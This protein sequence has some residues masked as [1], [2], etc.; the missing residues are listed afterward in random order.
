M[1]GMHPLRSL[2]HEVADDPAPESQPRGLQF[3][4][5]LVQENV[6]RLRED[7]P[8]L[9]LPPQIIGKSPAPGLRIARVHRIVIIPTSVHHD[10]VQFLV[11]GQI[12]QH[13]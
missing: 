2:G 11:G 8:A 9:R 6:A 7:G 10:P 1:D 13:I 12:R 4:R 3:I 5:F